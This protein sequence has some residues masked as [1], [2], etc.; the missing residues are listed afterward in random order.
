MTELTWILNSVHKSIDILQRQRILLSVVTIIESD[1]SEQGDMTELT[2]IL[3][4]VHKPY[5]SLQSRRVP[6]SVV[7]RIKVSQRSTVT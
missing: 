7:T 6:L 2:P 4:S 5:E 1:C 3:N